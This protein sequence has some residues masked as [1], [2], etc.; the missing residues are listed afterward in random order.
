MKTAV[1][2]TPKEITPNTSRVKKKEAY[3]KVETEEEDAARY[4][5]RTRVKEGEGQSL[6]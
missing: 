4:E 6:R 2:I 5:R 3:S 1:E